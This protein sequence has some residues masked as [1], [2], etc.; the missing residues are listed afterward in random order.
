MT[1]VRLARRALTLA[2]A[3]LALT[4]PAVGASIVTDSL[5][6]ADQWAARTVPH[7]PNHCAGGRL[8]I[9]WVALRTVDGFDILGTADGWRW[10]G[11]AWEWDHAA[12]EVTI[13]RGQ[14]VLSKCEILVHELLHFVIGPQHE[15]PLDPRHP[16]PPACARLAERYERAKSRRVMLRQRR[17]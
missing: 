1:A 3:T 10:N 11:H 8:S 13:A 16:A 5:A 14:G 17:R 9:A 2:A 12:C 4:A 6:I 7:L 15:G